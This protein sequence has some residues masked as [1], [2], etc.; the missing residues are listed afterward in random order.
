MKSRGYL[1][2]N[3]I[4][5]LFVLVMNA[6]SGTGFFNGR[7]VGEVSGRF[8]NTF[9]PAGYVFAIWGLIYLLLIAFVV[10]QWMAWSKGKGEPELR[11][12]GLWFALANLANGFWIVAWLNMHIGLSVLI[13][14]VLL[15]SLIVLAVRLKLELWD[16]PLRIIAFVWWPLTV[17]LGWIIVAVVANMTVYLTSIGWEGGFLTEGSWTIL[18]IGVATIIYLLLINFRNM[19]E[20]S[21]VGIWAFIGIAVRQWDSNPEIAWMALA[22]SLVLL[23]SAGSHAYRN[24]ATLPRLRNRD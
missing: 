3:T 16:A 1:I 4:T 6:L 14:F 15:L 2:I 24:R 8:E 7:T 9:T 13:I 11:Q 5:L 18:M 22:A 19:R 12:T 23:V 20:A 17:Y 10:H 21:I